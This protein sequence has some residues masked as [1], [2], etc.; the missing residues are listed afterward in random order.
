[1][2]DQGARGSHQAPNSSRR[3]GLRALMEGGRRPLPIYDINAFSQVTA[4]GRYVFAHSQWPFL[5]F[6]TFVL[7]EAITK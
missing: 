4:V 1:M 3:C 6:H 7:H 2:A 5:E